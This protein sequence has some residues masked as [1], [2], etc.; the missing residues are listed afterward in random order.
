MT[1]DPVSVSGPLL[2]VNQICRQS[3]KSTIGEAEEKVTAMPEEGAV[4]RGGDGGGGGGEGKR[5]MEREHDQED[6]TREMLEVIDTARSFGEFRRTQRKECFN[7]VR[8]LQLV[9]PLLEEIKELETPISDTAF[10]RL[11]DLAEAFSD[12]KKLLRCCHDGSKIYLALESEAVVGKFRAVYEKLNRALAG[13]PYHELRITDEVEEQVELMNVQLERAKRRTD[14]QDMELAMD[15][16][17]VLSG[18]EDLDVDR[19]VLERLASRLQLQ[20]LPDLRAETMAIKKLIKD[21]CSQNAESTQQI[22]DL[23]DRFKQI[24]GIE[25]SNGLS[26][27]ALPKYLEKCPSLVI[28]NDFLCPISLEI[29]TDPVIVATGQTF[30]R[31]SIQI[32]LDAGHRTCPKTRQTLSHLSLAPNYALRNLI[33]QWC[34]KNKVELLKKETDLDSEAADHEEEISSL[35]EDLSSIHLDKQ[36]RA[37]KKI[38]MLSKENPDHRLAI[39]Q[40]GGIPALVSLL[41]YPDSKIQENTVTALLNLSIDEGNKKLI[42]KEGAVPSIIEI[43]KTG[44]VPAKEN[45]AAALFSLSMLDEIKLMIG[46]LNGMPPLIDLLQN[47]TIRGK[48]DAATALFNLV[49]NSKNKARAIEAGII[50]PVLQVLGE[51][52]LGMADEAL[53]I[54]FL[55]TLHP[56]GCNAIGQQS[57]I[58]TLVEFIKEGTPKNKEC[59]LSVLLELGSHNSSLLSAAIQLGVH[60]HLDEIVKSG[61]DRAQRKA[62]ALISNCEQV[63]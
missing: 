40:N 45:S 5:L 44:T 49:L 63:Q 24:A 32:W 38:R 42:A 7:L 29:M 3:L 56:D 2:R 14:T 43:L 10:A 57:F 54:L 1:T 27:V 55:L 50:A 48:K 23:L 35:V 15:L 52:N 31:R 21:R 13:M 9:A 46:N 41:T 36:R 4:A 22:I 28:P 62:K 6:L 51:T 19:A 59:A 17:V 39:A 34:E 37:V 61:T 33:L 12:A 25:D 11:C 8:R 18:E 47:G 30:E 58:Q 16:M 60:D 53:S 26:E 20:A